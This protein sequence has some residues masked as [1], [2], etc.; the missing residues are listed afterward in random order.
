MGT[1]LY[2]YNGSGYVVLRIMSSPKSFT[3]APVREALFGKNL[4]FFSESVGDP[5]L[6]FP[7]SRE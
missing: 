5:D 4:K 7:L 2:K 3:L 6:G 1:N